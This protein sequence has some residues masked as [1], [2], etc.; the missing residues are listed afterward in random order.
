MQKSLLRLAKEQKNLQ[1]IWMICSVILL[2]LI[3]I[4]N[5]NHNL[6]QLRNYLQDIAEETQDDV[7]KLLNSFLRVIS[8]LPIYGKHYTNC[9]ELLPIL[10]NAVQENPPLSGLAIRDDFNQM[11]C[12]TFPQKSPHDNNRII[13]VTL[14]GDRF[15][16][17]Q[18][19]L[20]NYHFSIYFPEKTLENILN[21]HVPSGNKT[22]F[23]YDKNTQKILASSSTNVN[24]N[25]A[26]IQ[27]LPYGITPLNTIDHIYLIVT[28]TQKT[29][30]KKQLVSFLIIT[31]FYALFSFL[32]YWL[33]RGALDKQYNLHSHLKYALK[34]QQFF[35]MFQ[36]IF[37]VKNNRFIGAEMLMRWKTTDNEI[38]MPDTFIE[39]TE[40]TDLIVPLTL[41]VADIAMDNYN[42]IIKPEKPFY[43]AFNMSA[44]HFTSP[45]FFAD[46]IKLMDKHA[47]K[48]EEILLEIT[49]RDLIN[50][51]DQI[52]QEKMQF[53]RKINFSLA[54]DDFGTGHANIS[55]LQHFPCNYLKID[56]LFVQSIGT[57]SV[58]ESLID[59]IISMAKALKL[60]IIAE[61][62][63]TKEQV[64]YL[65]ANQVQYLQ[66]WYYAQVMTAKELHQF[67]KDNL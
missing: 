20:G 12:S 8:P 36:P 4:Y 58:T 24:Q 3:L 33:T 46:F 50:K 27:K 43:L 26:D 45:T 55:Y 37:D 56:Q 60:T 48:P 65:I 52:Y 29:I 11:F 67:L 32:L 21:L 64:D 7:E 28:T 38:L 61:G 17:F 16:I 63:E 9:K 18:E 47:L 62:T 57:G 35:P 42:K 1:Y 51:N 2:I 49:E 14:N 54:I 40:K 44:H 66:G 13:P 6:Y 15:V 23:L 5:W 34:K 22:L 59:T 31:F 10:Q 19:H 39:E 53:L 25:L 30:L 41:Q